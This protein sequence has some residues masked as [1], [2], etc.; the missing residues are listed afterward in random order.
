MLSG[1]KNVNEVSAYVSL[2]EVYAHTREQAVIMRAS[3]IWLAT[4]HPTTDIFSHRSDKTISK[5]E[6]GTRSTF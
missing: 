2:G 6:A 4:T 5:K 3:C 1:E